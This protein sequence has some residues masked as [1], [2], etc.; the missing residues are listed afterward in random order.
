MS[1]LI[2]PFMSCRTTTM[3]QAPGKEVPTVTPTVIK[4]QE[5]DCAIWIKKKKACSLKGGVKC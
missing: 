2:C 5:A 1:K 4:C 3:D